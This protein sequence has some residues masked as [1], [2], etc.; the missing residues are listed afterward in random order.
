MFKKVILLLLICILSLQI[1]PTHWIPFIVEE[2]ESTQ[3]ISLN[4][5]EEDQN[6]EFGKD[7]KGKIFESDLLNISQNPIWA[8]L[9]VYQYDIQAKT[10]YFTKEVICP[11]PNFI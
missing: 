5:S 3:L 8:H 10:I 4:T 6:D 1:F 7:F 2:N 9:T 11:P